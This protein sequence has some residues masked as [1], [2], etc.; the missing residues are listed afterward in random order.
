M[1]AFTK[2]Y[3]FL[4]MFF[5]ISCG[6][7]E[8]SSEFAEVKT[9]GVFIDKDTGQKKFQIPE[10]TKKV[11]AIEFQ[12]ILNRPEDL[13][14]VIR[15]EATTNAYGRVL[16]TGGNIAKYAQYATPATS[17]VLNNRLPMHQGFA[18]RFLDENN[19]EI[20]IAPDVDASGRQ[21]KPQAAYI[22][23]SVFNGAKKQFNKDPQVYEYELFKS[24]GKTLKTYEISPDYFTNTVFPKDQEL[25]KNYD[26]LKDNCQHKAQQLEMIMKQDT[27]TEAEND[28]LANN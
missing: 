24:Q 13:P 6:M 23:G 27:P 16:Q 17:G 21:L 12:R 28:S 22:G 25:K 14:S 10:G 11:E 18:F 9:P 19:N 1:A 4:F 15:S 7:E 8:E 3:A 5:T 2:A 20:P 26:V